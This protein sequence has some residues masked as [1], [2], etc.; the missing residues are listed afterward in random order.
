LQYI[1]HLIYDKRRCIPIDTHNPGD[2]SNP[3]SSFKVLEERFSQWQMRKGS[4]E[5]PL[6]VDSSDYFSKFQGQVLIHEEYF[7]NMKISLENL[8]AE[9]D[10]KTAEYHQYIQSMSKVSTS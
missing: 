5:N 2:K 4:K 8:K 7:D 10:Q 9:V 3:V 6:P 1:A